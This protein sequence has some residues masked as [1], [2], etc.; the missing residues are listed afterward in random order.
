M[1][2][3]IKKKNIYRTYVGRT[4]NDDSL[5]RVPDL[6]LS[7]RGNSFHMSRQSPES[8]INQAKFSGQSRWKKRDWHYANDPRQNI[9]EEQSFHRPYKFQKAS[10]QYDE[11][12][13]SWNRPCAKDDELLCNEVSFQQLDLPEDSDAFKQQVQRAF[14][15]FSKVLNEDPLQRKL[16]EQQGKAGSLPCIVCSS[17]FPKDFIDTHSL[18]MH[19]FNSLK[20]GL[21]AEH[22]GLHKALCVLMGWNHVVPPDNAKGYQLLPLP[23]ARAMKEDLILWPPLVIVHNA[24]SEMKKD[25]SEHV[26]SDL[27]MDEILQGLGFSNGKMKVVNG[28]STI[29]GTL[30]VKFSPTFS[31]LQEAERLHKYCEDNHC[32]RSDWLQVQSQH[33]SQQNLSEDSDL[34]QADGNVKDNKKQFYGYIGIAGD[35]EKVDFDTKKRTLVKSRK[36]IEAITDGPVHGV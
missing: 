3:E 9:K 10:V 22:L 15:R 28:S 26:V 14:L 1:I 31:G 32:G 35:L 21:R 5:R 17:R 25:G 23:D 33:E 12:G 24:N 11:Q 13:T 36:D 16:Y 20:V 18:V 29:Q 7:P 34:L 8:K 19:T 30:L 27:D 4:S 2:G 6:R